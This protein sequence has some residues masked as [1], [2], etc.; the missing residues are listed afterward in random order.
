MRNRIFVVLLILPLLQACISGTVSLPPTD[1]S[2]VGGEPI[3]TIPPSSA[4]PEPTNTSIPTS[5]ATPEPTNTPIPSATVTPTLDAGTPV[6]GLEDIP[7]MPGAFNGEFVDDVTY[8]YAV[9]ATVEEVE[10]Y[11][12][13]TMVSNDWSLSNREVMEVSMFTGPTTILEF[14]RDDQ[15]AYIMLFHNA[16][17]NST[18]VFM[19]HAN[20]LQLPG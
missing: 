13:E 7:T 17:D 16:E 18:I 20:P 5:S 15:S 4:T 6:P 3:Q 10:T 14:Q 12:T 2:Q 1:T 19:S 11:Y 8:T 9:F